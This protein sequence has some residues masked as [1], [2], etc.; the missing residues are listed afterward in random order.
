MYGVGEMD[1]SSQSCFSGERSSPL[2]KGGFVCGGP[3]NGFSGSDNGRS[4]VRLPD[5]EKRFGRFTI[6]GRDMRRYLH[7][8]RS[9]FA[10][11]RFCGVTCLPIMRMT[12]PLL[13]PGKRNPPCWKRKRSCIFIYRNRKRRDVWMAGRRS[14][15]VRRRCCR[16]TVVRP[17]ALF[18]S[19]RDR[20][21]RNGRRDRVVIFR[22]F[23]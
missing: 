3:A 18:E 13:K 14:D 9:G 2:P 7:P 4:F 10:F 21:A 5:E 19:F 11:A 12:G 8:C 6:S 20:Y 17:K 16:F 15:A 22:R 23:P 1:R